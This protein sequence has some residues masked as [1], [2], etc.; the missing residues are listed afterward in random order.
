MDICLRKKFSSCMSFL[1]TSRLISLGCLFLLQRIQTGYNSIIA[2]LYYT[3]LRTF[4]W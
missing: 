1:A 3:F 2:E 4:P